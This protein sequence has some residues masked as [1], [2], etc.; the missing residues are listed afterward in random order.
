MDDKGG[1]SWCKS[2]MFVIVIFNF[3]D[4]GRKEAYFSNYTEKSEK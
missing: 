3:S 4:C 1:V 2:I